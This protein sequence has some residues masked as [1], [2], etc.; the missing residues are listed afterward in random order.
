MSLLEEMY[1]YLTTTLELSRNKALGLI[2]NAERESGLQTVV[3]GDNGTS[4]G[5]FQW[6]GHRLTNLKASVPN[7]RKSWKAQ[8]QYALTEDVGPKYLLETFSNPQEAAHWWMMHWARPKNKAAARQKN[9]K[10][11]SLYNF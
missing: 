10:F 8:F 5:I 1:H 7:W 3:S 6:H 9:N 2:A 4:N 11:L